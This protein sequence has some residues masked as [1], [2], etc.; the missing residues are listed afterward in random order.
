M[1]K[2][3][4]ILIVCLSSSTFA[5]TRPL[6]IT[7]Y[8]GLETAYVTQKWSIDT[9]GN[10]KNSGVRFGVLTGVK[11]NEFF[12]LE[13]SAHALK[14]DTSA[15]RLEKNDLFLGAPITNLNEFHQVSFEEKSVSADLFLFSP[16]IYQFRTLKTRRDLMSRVGIRAFAFAGSSFKKMKFY[17]ETTFG[18]EEFNAPRYFNDLIEMESNVHVVPRVGAGLDFGVNP[19]TAIRFRASYEFNSK[20]KLGHNENLAKPKSYL[21]I[22]LSLSHMF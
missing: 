13:F 18:Q 8:I 15:K 9:A 5:K 16:K 20:I 7:P 12:G 4:F 22:N 1:R 2:E 3:L 6:R 14:S 11:I 17:D 19:N 21:S 10:L